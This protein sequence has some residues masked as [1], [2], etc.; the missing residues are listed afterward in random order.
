GTESLWQ[1]GATLVL[2][3]VI[4]QLENNLLVPKVMERA[5]ALHPL[6]V[7]LALITGGELLGIGGA[8]VA[9]PV[10]AALA[11]ALDELRPRDPPGAAEAPAVAHHLHRD[12]VA[13]R[14]GVQ[15]LGDV[16]GAVDRLP[17]HLHDHVSALLVAPRAAPA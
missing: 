17:R 4:Q 16:V 5:V 7:V 3:V 13:R 1:A 9:V 11:V 8:L 15:R 6:A 10:A 14:V 2:Y 12:R